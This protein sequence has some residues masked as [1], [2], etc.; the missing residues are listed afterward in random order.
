MPDEVGGADEVGPLQRRHVLGADAEA[1]GIE[2]AALVLNEH[3]PREVVGFDEELE[4]VDRALL[5][6][7][8]FGVAGEAG[9]TAGQ[10]DPVV[11]RQGQP[12][13][14]EVVEVLADPAV[15][16]VHGGDMHALGVV[17]MATVEGS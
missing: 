7:P 15:R 5:G 17:P 8:R 9:R 14:E 16:A 4:F 3:D 12:V 13:L 6:D 10:R 1:C 2:G 11:P